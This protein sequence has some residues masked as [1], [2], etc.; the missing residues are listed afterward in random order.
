M[1]SILEFSR[2]AD[3]H[4]ALTFVEVGCYG[5]T[6]IAWI[7]LVAALASCLG[8]VVWMLRQQ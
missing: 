5:I 4:F 7:L 2:C 8:A 6:F 3:R 1:W